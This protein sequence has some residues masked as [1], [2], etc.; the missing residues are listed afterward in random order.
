LS[1]RYPK[2]ALLERIGASHRVIEASAGT[3]K[4]YT[5]EHLL[6]QLILEPVPLENLLVVT[7][8]RKAAL[9]LAARVRAKL[10]ELLAFEGSG[11][12]PQGPF[13]ELGEAQLELLRRALLGFDRATICTIHAFCKQVLDD[14]A[15][16]GGH[17]FEQ[18]NASSEEL[19]DRA[20]TTLLRTEY[21]GRQPELLRAALEQLGL[22]RLRKLLAQALGEAEQ[23]DVPEFAEVGELLARFPEAEAR[24]FLA[25]P[26]AALPAKARKTAVE[27]LEKLLARR[28]RALESGC[29]A[30]FWADPDWAMDTLPKGLKHFQDEGLEDT[31]LAR[32]LAG[33]ANFPAVLVAAFLPPLRAELRRHK[34]EAGL[35]DFDDMIN[36]VGE[37]LDSAQGEA[38][39][40]RL[41]TRYQV[42]LIDEFQDTDRRQWGIFRRLFLEGGP[43]RR[44]FLVGD[45]KQAI[46]G[47]RGGDLPTYV[48]ALAQVAARTGEAPL[49]LGVNFRS[50]PGVIEAY[51]SVLE[52]GFFSGENAGHY[53]EPVTCGRP[54]LRLRDAQGLE[55][56]ALLAVDV[57]TQGSARQVGL[58]AARALARALRGTLA[59]GF[60]QDRPLRPED[61]FVLTAKARE[62]RVMAAA[63]REEGIPAA[64][65]R[66]DGLFDGPEAAAVRDLLLAMEAP[67]DEG[68][69]AKALL[70]PFFGLSLGEA[71][72]ARDLP[73][74]HPVLARLYGWRDLALEGRYGELFSRLV[75]ESGV[76]R[77]LLFLEPN[78][79]A[80]TNLEHILELLQQ[81]ALAGH[82]TLAGLAVQV[83][84]WIDGEDRPAVEDGSTQRLERQGGAVQIL[85]MHK[86][87]G[88]QAPVVVLFGGTAKAQDGE[89]QRYHDAAGARRAW[90]GKAATAPSA[91]RAAIEREG[92]A[93]QER[94]AYVAL[95]RA[96]AQLLLARYLEGATSPMGNFAADGNPKGGAY[97]PIN[98]RLQALL[99][100]PAEP[101]S[102]PRLRRIPAPEQEPETPARAQPALVLAAPPLPPRPDFQALRRLARPAWLFSFTTL[103][104]GVE[105]ARG[106]TGAYPEAKEGVPAAGPGGGRKLGT[107]VHAFL[108][109]VDLASVRGVDFEG[110]LAR[111]ET[112]RLA[113]ACL[114][115]EGRREALAWVYAALAEPL[116]LPG[117][118]TAVLAEAEETLRELDFMTPYPGRPDFLNGSL[119]VL[120]RSGGRAFVLDWKTNRLEDY[121]P[122]ALAASVDAHY[123]LQ[124]R[125]YA[126]TACRFLGI[127]DAAAFEAGF[128]GVVYVFLRGLPG[129]GVWTCRP[130][131]AEL[132]AWEREIDA[133]W[134]E[135]WIPAHAG[136][137]AAPAGGAE[138]D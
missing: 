18:E 11:D 46:Y 37:A 79:R 73:E 138:H 136:G 120:F 135:Q 65:Y 61:V 116:A 49:H 80:L 86:S 34:Q 44:L 29:P 67:L 110:W 4:T 132:Q 96:E 66:Q 59:T 92:E 16:E 27:L 36:L 31:P 74:G 76:S 20:F 130:S 5:L 81:R 133:L 101:R 43:G 111:P 40:A 30:S 50:T 94:L 91:V 14:A 15:F 24:A 45:P 126:V 128:G 69:R 90:V 26:P 63:L 32:A 52:E 3:G 54:E 129:D 62:G 39:A 99:G 104:K 106:E 107:Q 77:R 103:Q 102:H 127:R 35:Y 124:V 64:L 98:R 109:R 48:D 113:E 55:L 53:G 78:Q 2:P 89:V 115:A 108:E 119:D 8:T 70:G 83:Q 84:R 33:L 51:N 68:R 21:A 38:L 88:L 82:C 47:F 71:E 125:I 1:P 10:A 72:R 56:P 123:L 95:T 22:A 25:R 17:L 137:T 118:G 85:T 105:R 57:P 42:A 114:P 93:E 9:E 19:F 131:W 60:F 7:Y 134:P 13:W 112:V 87:K 28:A 75:G 23:L 41:R 97:R 12:A 121:G 117:G 122:E 58:R 100:S 6:V